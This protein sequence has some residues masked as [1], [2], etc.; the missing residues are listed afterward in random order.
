MF[1]LKH[2]WDRCFDIVASLGI[3][4]LVIGFGAESLIEDVITGLFMIAE[5]QYNV[6]DIVEVNGLR[7]LS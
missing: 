5:N 7:V 1:R 4:A 3:V 2:H 6:N